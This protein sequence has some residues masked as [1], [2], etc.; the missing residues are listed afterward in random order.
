[1][2][3]KENRENLTH[4]TVLNNFVSDPFAAEAIACLQALDFAFEMGFT[5]VQMEGDSRSTIVKINQVLPDFSDMGTFIEEI[6]IKGGSFQRISFHHIDRRA[7]MVAHMIAKEG[8]SLLE[9]RFWVEEIPEVA[10]IFLA[11][12]LANLMPQNLG[13]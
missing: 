7:N 4:G 12:D 9:D 3:T 5:H 8:F 1:M 11:R 6:K 2:A 13:I 10:K